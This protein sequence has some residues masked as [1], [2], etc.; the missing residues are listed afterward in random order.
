MTYEKKKNQLNKVKDYWVKGAGNG[1][2]AC[3]GC[4]EPRDDDQTKAT[5]NRSFCAACWP[6][7]APEPN[8]AAVYFPITFYQ[9]FS[10]GSFAT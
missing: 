9:L 8:V 10:F 4:F 1:V 3:A 7:V 6:T 2:R 5:C